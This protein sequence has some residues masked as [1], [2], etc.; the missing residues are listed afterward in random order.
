MKILSKTL[1]NDAVSTVEEFGD[2]FLIASKLRELANQLAVNRFEWSP[3]GESPLCFCDYP[4][5]RAFVGKTQARSLAERINFRISVRPFSQASFEPCSQ[6]VRGIRDC[7][8]FDVRFGLHFGVVP[9]F[10][11]PMGAQ[12]EH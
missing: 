11:W 4:R 12:Q 2:F 6:I 7:V 9:I 5:A 3:H 10:L 1:R 8:G